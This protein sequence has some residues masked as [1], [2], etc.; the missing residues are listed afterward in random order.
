MER[1]RWE[2]YKGKRILIL[3]YSGL[4]AVKP[5]DK[6]TVMELIKTARDLSAKQTTPVLFL[7]DVTGSQADSETIS[8]IKEFAKFNNETKI[9][10]KECVIGTTGLQTVLLNAINLF[11]GGNIKP[12]A[13]KE[14]AQEWLVS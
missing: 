8:A 7:S 14:Q 13:T 4:K 6:K 10:G 3:D 12:F 11:S 5:E 2:T 1:V 9:V